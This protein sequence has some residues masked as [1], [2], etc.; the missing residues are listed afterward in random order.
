MYFLLRVVSTGYRKQV[1]GTETGIKGTEE[2]GDQ[3]HCSAGYR[4]AY[5]VLKVVSNALR[6]KRY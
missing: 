3:V 1:Q 4:G 2:R 5:L 6:K